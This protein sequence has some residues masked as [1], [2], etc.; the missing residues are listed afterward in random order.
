MNTDTDPR[1]VELLLGAAALIQTCGLWKGEYWP[2]SADAQVQAS[3]EP[4]EDLGGYRPGGY[5]PADPCCAMGALAV[6]GG[7][8][9]IADPRPLTSGHQLA[10][11]VTSLEL[12]ARGCR[13][14]LEAFNDAEDTTAAQVADVLRSAARRLYLTVPLPDSY[15]VPGG[16]SAKTSHPAGTPNHQVDSKEPRHA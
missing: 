11:H 15:S 13:R 16:S 7:P 5:I 3:D 9:A 4:T 12:I 10:L 8:E 2:G 6:A 14:R 1:A